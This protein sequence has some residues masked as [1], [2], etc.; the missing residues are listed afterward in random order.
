EIEK[1]IVQ[2]GEEL[3]DQQ[4][5]GLI[6]APGFSTAAKVTDIS[7]RG[8]GMDVV[9]RNIDQLR[10][11]VE[12]T[13][14]PGKGSTFSIRLP[15]TLAIIDGMVVQVGSER[16]IIPTILIEQTLRPLREQVS[17]VQQRGEVLNNRGR[18]V[19]LIQLGAMFGLTG[20]VDPCE[21]MVVIAQCDGNPI[22]IVVEGLLGQQQV[23]IK[24]LGERFQ[25][26]RGVSGAAILSDGRVGLILE[27]SGLAVAHDHY[28]APQR[29]GEARSA[30]TH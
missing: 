19:P 26:L 29:R 10:G 15:L 20:W 17:L 21:A 7:G 12:I 9:K 8:V 16:L 11:K 18:L 5:F 23:V 22:G 14:E 27:T 28:R 2:P 24:S 30:S 25:K 3:T 13:S 1:G 6:F 4:V